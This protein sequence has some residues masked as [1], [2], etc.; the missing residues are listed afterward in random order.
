MVDRYFADGGLAALYDL[1]CPWERRDDLQ[2][3]LERVMTADSVLDVGC[4]TG[5]LLRQARAAG[6][7]GRLCG[8]DP[9]AGMLAQARA[10]LD[11]D[12]VLGDLTTATWDQEFDL[13]VMSGNA[14]QVFTDDTMLCAALAAIH[15]AL[16]PGGRFAFETR[17]PL[18]R[19]WEGW[20]P[21][22]ATQVTTGTGE[23]VRMARQVERVQGDLVAFSHTFT[24]PA[25][26]AA[27]TSRSTLRF[28]GADR[29]AAALDEAG[30]QIMEQYG[31][32]AGG[33]LSEVSLEIVTIAARPGGTALDTP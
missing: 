33:P 26:D 32:F 9:A 2:F 10:N 5:A 16:K 22:Q 27:E 20:S 7:R 30:L 3:Y 12:W 6:H 11:V 18:A 17:N 19:E 14:F 4:G 1:F 13:V 23:V 24:S 29:L 25:W 28:L 15:A 8:L 31:D 21:A